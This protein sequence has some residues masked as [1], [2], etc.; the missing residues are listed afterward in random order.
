M[1]IYRENNKEL[2]SEKAK[3]TFQCECGTILRIDNKVRHLKT[4][5]HKKYIESLI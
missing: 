5:K 3:E 4:F 1:E 2:I